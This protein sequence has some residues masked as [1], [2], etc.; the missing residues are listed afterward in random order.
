MVAG[1]TVTTWV[2]I[3]DVHGNVRALRAALD[4]MRDG[5]MDRLVFLGDLLTYGHDVDEVIQL[6]ETAQAHDDAVLLIGNHDRLYFDLQAGRQTLPA[7]QL[8]DWIRDSV[9]LSCEKLG[10]MLLE[11]RLAW[12]DEYFVDGV[13]AAHAN[14]FGAGDFRYLRDEQACADATAALRE[15]G[16]L[17]GVFGHTHRPRWGKNGPDAVVALDQDLSS[18]L[19]E[20]LLVNAGAIGQPRGTPGRSAILRMTF[21]PGRV[22]GRFEALNYD[23]GA[24][25]ADLRRSGLP[26]ETV[27]RL[28]RYFTLS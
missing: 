8:P 18:E 25:V 20:P 13:L 7:A 2:V 28:C 24:H 23:V 15:R 26:P 22:T 19:T 1:S 16:A 14:P 21:E 9:A 5:P 17:V 4:R 12:R 6:V 11:E 3:G 10:G 27:E